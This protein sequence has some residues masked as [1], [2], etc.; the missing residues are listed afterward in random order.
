MFLFKQKGHILISNDTN[1]TNDTND[2]INKIFLKLYI[3]HKDTKSIDEI[4]N[5]AKKQF[6]ETLD[7]IY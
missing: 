1:D 4:R 6:Y 7:C 2:S 3:I 5:M